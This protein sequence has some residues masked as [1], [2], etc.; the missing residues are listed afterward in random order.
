MTGIKIY[1]PFDREVQ[2]PTVGSS[3]ITVDWGLSDFGRLRKEI[4]LRQSVLIDPNNRVFGDPTRLH[5]DS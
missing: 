1:F 4:P 5:P 3:S 2:V